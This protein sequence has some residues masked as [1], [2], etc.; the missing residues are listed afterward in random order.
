[1]HTEQFLSRDS[2]HISCHTTKQK[3]PQNRKSHTFTYLRKRHMYTNATKTN[4][5]PSYPFFFLK[6]ETT[7][8]PISVPPAPP[9][10]PV[11]KQTPRAASQIFAVRSQEAVSTRRLS[12]CRDFSGA[13][14]PVTPLSHRNCEGSDEIGWSLAAAQTG[15]PRGKQ[16]KWGVCARYM[17]SMRQGWPPDRFA[18]SGRV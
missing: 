10:P 4:T 15:N 12:A 2:S 7:T 5:K 8:D 17:G 3:E 1:M 9:I 18:G 11:F 16:R 6:E 13:R 14:S